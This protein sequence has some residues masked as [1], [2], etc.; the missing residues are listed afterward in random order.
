MLVNFHFLRPWLLVLLLVP[1]F[2]YTRYFHGRQNQSSWEKVCDKKLLPYLLIKGSSSQRKVMAFLGLIGLISAIF[3]ASGPSWNKIEIPSLAPENP[4]M[5][6]LNLSSEMNKTDLTPSRLERTKYK[7]K[8]FLAMLKG[9][10]VGLIVYSNEPFLISPLTEDTEIISNLLPAISL[11]IMPTNGDRLDRAIDLAVEK[12]QAAAYQ[13]GEIVIFAPDSGQKFDLALEAAKKAF[14]K[15]FIVNV[16][17]TNSSPVEKLK[18]IAEAG[19]GSYQNLQTNDLELQTLANKFNAHPTALKE[20]KNWQSVWLDYG[21]YMLPLPLL[22]CLYFFRKGILIIALLLMSYPA[23]AGF[24]KNANQEGFEAFN[25]QDYQRAAN[26]FN[27]SSWLGASL[28]RMGD[29]EKAYREFAK[30]DDVTSLYN[31]GNALAKSGKIE[32]AIKKY[33][34]VLEKDPHHEDAQFN[35][36]YLKRQQQNQQQQQN[37]SQNNENDQQQDSQQNQDSSG[38]NEGENQGNNDKQN[39]QGSSENDNQ[40]DNHNDND[41]QNS[42]QDDPDDSKQESGQDNQSQNQSGANNEEQ[43]PSQNGEQ[44]QPLGGDEKENPQSQ[45][46]QSN[47]AQDG[48]KDDDEKFD[49]QGQAR[50]QQYREIPEDPGGLLKA[51]IYKEYNRNRYQDK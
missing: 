35:L 12:M 9:T 1:L 26:G 13:Q 21:Y 31:Q 41:Q 2:F 49:E 16:I 32:D 45:N 10:Q 7:I 39:N 50:A 4:I 40:S 20:S 23:Q 25:M 29:Y 36:D 11:D 30:N 3:A 14:A 24:F 51:F 47:N 19:G 15:K 42:S 44:K 33:E 18:L 38:S 6:A 43:N 8:D 34:E 46:P 5:I 48:E 28:Y 27:D 37:Q 17:A 22:C